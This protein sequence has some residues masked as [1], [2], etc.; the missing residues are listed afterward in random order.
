MSSLVGGQKNLRLYPLYIAGVSFFAWMPVFFLYFSSR[1]SLA[2]VLVLEAIYYATVVVLE[3]PSGYVSDRFGRKP[4]LITAA[5]ALTASYAA[6]ALATS[7]AGLVV[8]QVLLAVGLA[9]NSGT[10]TSFHLASL[11]MADK[12]VEYGRREAKLSTLTFLIGAT[13]AVVGGAVALA[14]LRYAYGLALC[15]AVVALV[16]AIAF[17]SVESVGD[18]TTV[19]LGKTLARCIQT[20]WDRRLG[21]FFAAV[22]VA[23]IVNHVPYEFYQPYLDELESVPW[24]PDGTPLAAGLHVAMVLLVAA[25]VAGLSTRLAGRIGTVPLVVAS[26][27][28]QVGLIASMAWFVSP[29]VAILLIGRAIPRALQDAPI[30][31][32]VAPRVAK[33]LRATYLSLQSLAGRLGFAT[34]LV[35][36]SLAATDLASVLQ[37]AVWI[38]VGLLVAVAVV[39][40]LAT[41]KARSGDT[42]DASG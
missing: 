30:R 23:T 40:G 3:V 36:L 22:V 26:L 28:L 11:E 38:G 39:A 42:P 18:R 20:A 13:S 41:T 32:E 14:D 1:V 10:D 31:A 24:E 2:D 12:A 8:G 7:F 19:S 25:P 15:G 37:L 17:V 33:E 27:A 5:A 4:T 21:W 9:F 6:F 35:I 29:W 34:L 16:V